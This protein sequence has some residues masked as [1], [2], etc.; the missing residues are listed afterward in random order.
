MIGFTIASFI[1]FA[2]FVVFGAAKFGLLRSYS[3]Y[4]AKWD[5]AVPMESDT[6]LWSIVTIVCAFMMAIPMIE[7]G[8]GSPL[9]FLGLFTPGYLMAVGFTPKYETV[10]KQRI[11]HY[12]CTALCATAAMA[13]LIF[14]RHDSLYIL[15]CAAVL[16][17]AA[18][19]SKTYRTSIVFWLEMIMFASVFT[20]LLF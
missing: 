20:S 3:A 17:F 9:Q 8:V 4:A 6:H 16:G 5:E 2:G 1:L 19:C 10:R 12:V 13:W 11:I 18:Y 15:C 7:A 14:V